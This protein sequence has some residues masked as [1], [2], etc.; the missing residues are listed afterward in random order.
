LFEKGD[1]QGART[2]LETALAHKPDS[3]NEPKI[4]QLLAKL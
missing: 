1:K 4:R 2:E 3:A